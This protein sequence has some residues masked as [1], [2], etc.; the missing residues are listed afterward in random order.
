MA[1]ALPGF[2]N[3]SKLF[4]FGGS[5]TAIGLSIGTSSIKLVELQ[6]EKKGYR[7]IHFGIVQL[8]DEA[9]VNREIVNSIAVVDALKTLVSQLRLSSKVCV[10]SV[11]GTFLIIKRMTLEIPNAREMQDQI[12][13]E[14]EQ[15]LPFDVSEVVMDYHVISRSKE[16]KT[17][18]LLVAM[19]RSV[20]DS[21]MAVSIDGGLKPKTVDVDYFALQNTLE[22]NYPQ[23]PSESVAVIDIGANALKMVIV[24]QGI[25]VFTKE[26]ALGGRNL[27]AD[28]Q[29]H[30]NLNFADAEALKVSGQN[31]AVPQEVSELVH[32]A[33]ENF[34]TEIKRTLDFHLASS[35]G[36][37]VSYALLT[38][39]SAKIP[40]LSKIVEDVIQIPTQ[41]MN[42]FTAVSYDPS[43]FT[44]E[45]IAAIAPLA[46]VAIGNA[47][48]AGD[49]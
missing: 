10:L 47:I 23:N 17:D 28:I 4:N 11:S 18:A 24:H 34:A 25:P 32:V 45:Y 8:P 43:V 42:P 14:A 15:Y 38:G 2:A 33:C 39:G 6:R 19:K 37:P 30:M 44:P 9:I 20:L 27:T 3:I 13:W 1:L 35:P 22:L 40:N 41:V 21:Y 31:G 26:S 36:A 5:S 48:R 46:G 49:A 29:R 16:G 12:F 7:L